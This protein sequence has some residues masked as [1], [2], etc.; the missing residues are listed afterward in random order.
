[1]GVPGGVCVIAAAPRP[2][3]IIMLLSGTGRT[4]AETNGCR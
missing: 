4:V 1:M 3:K 2:K